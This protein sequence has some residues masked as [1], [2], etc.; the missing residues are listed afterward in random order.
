MKLFVGDHPLK[1]SELVALG[2][3][4][5]TIDLAPTAI[6]R[7]S[8]SRNIADEHLDG[9]TAVYGLNVGLGANVAMPLE[10]SST[11]E[12]ERSVL[13]GRMIGVG[14]PLPEDVSRRALGI[15]IVNLCNGHSAVSPHVVE[16]LVEM[17]NRGLTPIVASQ[18][19]VGS[20][21]L[22]QC[23]QLCATAL[24]I[25]DVWYQGARTAALSALG[26]VKLQPIELAAKDALGLLNSGAVTQSAAVGAAEELEI[27]LDAA[28][29][30]AVASCEAYGVN[31]GP[32]LSDVVA[33][34]Y[35]PGGEAASRLIM[36]LLSGSWT[37]EDGAINQ[38]QHALS[39]RT[40][41]PLVAL[42]RSHVQ[43]FTELILNECN[44]SND[45][46]V[47]LLETREI[48]SSS[49]FQSLAVSVAG[50]ALSIA[51]THWSNAAA[52]R[53]IRMANAS[54]QGI[55][56][57]LAPS[58][59]HSVGFNALMKSTV[60]MATRVRFEANPAGL[61][62]FAISENAEDVASQFPLVVEKL[63][64]QIGWLRQLVAIEA[65][66]AHQMLCLRGELA[67][68]KAA[69]KVV[70]VVG[71]YVPFVEHDQPLGQ[72]VEAVS[73]GIAR[74]ECR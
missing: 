57:Y 5:T 14:N 32:F 74:G 16:Q 70:D 8:E 56:R 3:S 1:L 73:N 38:A 37:L 45:N 62:F 15:R 55:P 4:N 53:T 28:I 11:A 27:L 13:E 46:P 59:G 64:R 71:K 51:L 49:N 60:A 68:G 10:R 2:N 67:R 52:N 22:G 40:L 66:T 65:M 9:K 48:R 63:G 58:E 29:H 61:D 69:S 39:F 6:R 43:T 50:D 21:D 31:P 12:F 36:S 72:F 18:G 42:L 7:I 24:G 47:V 44:S 17:Y 23:A 25:G 35:L 41:V 26:A 34:K 54:I 20:S 19:S 30:I 33:T